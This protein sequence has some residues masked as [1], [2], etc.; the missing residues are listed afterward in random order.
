MYAYMERFFNI[1]NMKFEEIYDF[2]NLYQAAK[3]VLRSKAKNAR[4]LEFFVNLEENLIN[5]QNHLIYHSYSMGKYNSFIVKDPKERIIYAPALKDRVTQTALC[6]IIEPEIDKHFIYDSYACRIGKGTLKAANRI[7]YWIN[8]SN[9]EYFLYGDIE[10]FFDSIDI[11]ILTEL[12]KRH[13]KDKNI[14]WLIN[15]ILESDNT[16]KGIKKGNRLSQLAANIYLHEMDFYIK[17]VLHIKYYIRYM[18]D[19][20]IF[21][22]NINKLKEYKYLIS[23]FVEESLGLKL[24]KRTCVG[25]TANG[26]SFVGYR[27]SKIDKIIKKRCIN[28]SKQDFKLW[29]NNKISNPEFYRKTASR[30]GHCRGTSSY[31]WYCSYLLRITGI[32]LK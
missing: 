4:K 17:N 14:L 3:E 8:K 24:N 5:I 30:V 32:L 16:K 13:V 21:S 15:I 7:S 26:V 22:N 6:R 19:F 29:K 20:I 31:R 18:D 27:I 9:T 25:K 10:H 28:N 23:S 1:N 2:E 11:Q 12:F